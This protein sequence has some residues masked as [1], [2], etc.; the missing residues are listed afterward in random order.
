MISPDLAGR[1]LIMASFL[2]Y[3]CNAPVISDAEYDDLSLDVITGW[4]EISPTIQFCLGSADEIAST[5]Q[6]VKITQRLHYGAL[7]WAEKILGYRPDIPEWDPID[8]DL[9]R[10]IAFSRIRG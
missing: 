9:E 5:G 2:Y 3:D 10:D 4:D 1:R 7:A 6:G 8:Y